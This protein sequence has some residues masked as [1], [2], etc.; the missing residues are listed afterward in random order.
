MFG[1]PQN[2]NKTVLKREKFNRISMLNGMKLEGVN[3]FSSRFIEILVGIQHGFSANRTSEPRTLTVWVIAWVGR[4]IRTRWSQSS[5]SIRVSLICHVCTFVHDDATGTS[6]SDVL[7]T[8][9]K[10]DGVGMISISS[11]SNTDLSKLKLFWCTKTCDFRANL[12]SFFP[13]SSFF[14]SFEL[15]PW[16]LFFLRAFF[17]LLLSV[18]FSS[19]NGADRYT[20]KVFSAKSSSLRNEESAWYENLF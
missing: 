17:H 6:L 18:M 14:L 19:T 12:G 20:E 15:V 7:V 9:T 16:F 10:V 2:E 1:R 8:I 11:S 5:S 13:L 3:F 4:H